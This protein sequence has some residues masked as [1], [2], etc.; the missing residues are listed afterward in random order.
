MKPVF[1]WL[2]LIPVAARAAAQHPLRHPLDA[3]ETRYSRAQ[4][5]IRYSLRADSADPSGFAMA[6]NR[7]S[8][9]YGTVIVSGYD[10]PTVRVE[11][12]PEATARQAALRA[13]W[14]AGK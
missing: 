1:C 2:L 6:V 14:L 5:V 12:I 7:P 11:E 4:P 10:R 9:P 3:I 13:A 8:G